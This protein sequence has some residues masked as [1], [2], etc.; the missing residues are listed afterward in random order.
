MASCPICG[1]SNPRID[2]RC[3]DWAI[4]KIERKYRREES[5][6]EV[7]DEQEPEFGERLEDGFKMLSGD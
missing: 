3:P 1:K 2:H 7:I 4:R 5:A 6:A